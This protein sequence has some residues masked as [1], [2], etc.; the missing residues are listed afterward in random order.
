MIHLKS[1]GSVKTYPF[2]RYCFAT[3]IRN[4]FF[5][6]HFFRIFEKKLSKLCLPYSSVP[7][8]TQKMMTFH[9]GRPPWTT[10]VVT[11]C[12]GR[13]QKK[14]MH[15]SPKFSK[16]ALFVLLNSKLKLVLNPCW[17]WWYL[18][19]HVMITTQAN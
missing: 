1:R 9:G 11:V 16:N 18:N 12:S 17:F 6:H 14:K 8:R 5:L 2:K 19:T 15:F 10:V 13:Q 3:T 4:P 7:Q